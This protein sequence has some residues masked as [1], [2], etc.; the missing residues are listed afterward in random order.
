VDN[1]RVERLDWESEDRTPRGQDTF[2]TSE[3][4]LLQGEDTETDAFESRTSGEP[5]APPDEL[6]PDKEK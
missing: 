1:V 3:E 4:V 2:R 5:L 6:I